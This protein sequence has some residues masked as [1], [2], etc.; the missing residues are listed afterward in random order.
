MTSGFNTP[1]P[2]YGQLDLD[3]VFIT[4]ASLVDQFVGNQLWVWG[5]NNFGGLGNGTNGTIYSSPIQIGSL[6]TWK[7]IACGYYSPAMIK[8][9]GTLW[10][11]GYN[12]LG[13]LG[14]G[15]A[16]GGYSSPIQVGSLT[17][18]KQVS[19]GIGGFLSAI[20]TD[21]T[22]WT[23]GYGYGGALGNNTTTNYSSP[24]QVGSLT[25][26]K[27]VA[28]GYYSFAAVKTDGTLWACGYN[29][30]GQLGN[31]TT[32]N[33]YSPIQVG[34]LT[35]WKQ[36]SAYGYTSGGIQTNGTLWMWG[37]GNDGALGNG[38][39]L[40]YS[41]PIQIGSLTNWKQLS[42]GYLTTAAIKTDGTLW[43]WG[44]NN[45][46]QLGNGTSGNFYMSPI[47]VGSLTNWK[48][49]SCGS[50][51]TA[52]IKTDGTLWAWGYNSQGQLGNNVL[53]NYSSPIQVGSLTNWK[54]V[55]VAVSITAAITY[56][57]IT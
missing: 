57:D 2:I 36:V 51:C 49:V 50:Y 30:S 41:S 53:T 24:I 46:G 17:N 18:W 37:Y 26:W 21:G 20:K 40:S 43:I 28:A 55:S 4:D 1:D 32:S 16:N 11:C 42:I 29:H 35:N 34:T 6:T 54:Q 39:Q 8:T 5:A 31:N 10:G 27:Q 15:V 48:Q 13:Q 25:N 3:D 19:Y 44:W 52:A 9:D 23:W 56:A 22:L 47:Q 14:I 38:T 7:S 45:Y 12:T 33:S